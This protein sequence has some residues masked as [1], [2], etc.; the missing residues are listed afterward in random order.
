MWLAPNSSLGALR[1]T[2]LHG[3]QRQQEPYSQNEKAPKLWPGPETMA[4]GWKEAM[5]AE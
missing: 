5:L 3:S 2:D 4:K 1:W